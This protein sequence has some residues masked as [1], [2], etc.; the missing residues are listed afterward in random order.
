MSF[1]P[2][3]TNKLNSLGVFVQRDFYDKSVYPK[4]ASIPIDMW[5]KKPLYGRVDE[6]NNSVYP[7]EAFL[8]QFNINGKTIF[9]LNFV[10][11]AFEDF[12]KRYEKFLFQGKL[13]NQD[14]ELGQ[15]LPEEAWL[16]TNTLY[17]D[18]ISILYDSFYS[19][20]LFLEGR[21]EKIID[22]PSFL[23]IFIEWIDLTSYLYPF[24]KTGF[25]QSKYC[26][27]NISGLI[28][29]LKPH[30]HDNDEL[31]WQNFFN[32]GNFAFF[33]KMA[34]AHGF[35]IDKNA[36]WVLVADLNSPAMKP[37]LELN[38]I[39]LENLFTEFY[40]KSHQIDIEILKVYLLQ[41][42]NSLVTS[43]PYVR[44]PKQSNRNNGVITEI[45]TRNLYTM[46]QIEKQYNSSFWLRIMSYIRAREANIT[47]DQFQFD[48]IVRQAIEIEKFMNH[49]DA[50]NFLNKKFKN[51]LPLALKGDKV[52]KV[53]KS[54][55]DQSA[56]DFT[57]F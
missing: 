46:E 50:V 6:N 9:A 39:S 40:Y 7:S 33:S 11:D 20:F 3:A 12:K 30:K 51:K 14:T 37:Y 31:K 28:V 52:I 35:T 24:T 32:D 47:M 36:P 49:E 1:P 43:S 4:I 54:K 25:I 44:I 48:R 16:S 8:K 34:R 26:S 38:S 5:Y 29:K 22:F 57:F 41:F 2:S 56:K 27:P 15:I 53:R 17:H 42:Y 55:S 21:N 23:K 10:V 18:Y 19:N 45:K 13:K